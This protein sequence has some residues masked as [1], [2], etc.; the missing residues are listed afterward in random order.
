MMDMIPESA[1]QVLHMGA[2][3]REG[4]GGGEVLRRGHVDR[5]LDVAG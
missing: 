3:V 1:L 4:G 2:V 5:K